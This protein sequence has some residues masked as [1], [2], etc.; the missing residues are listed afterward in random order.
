MQNTITDKRIILDALVQYNYYAEN[1][2]LG[3]KIHM[4]KTQYIDISRLP[5]H[6]LALD[7]YTN[8]NLDPNY[9]ALLEDYGRIR[10][11]IIF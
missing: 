6:L 2:A 11:N 9:L 8:G 5:G 7:V 4:N 10:S 3:I 1:Y